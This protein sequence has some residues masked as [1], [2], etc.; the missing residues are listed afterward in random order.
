MAGNW[1]NVLKPFK[2][3]S[4]LLWIS[5]FKILCLKF[6]LNVQTSS[7]NSSNLELPALHRSAGSIQSSS[8]ALRRLRRPCTAAGR[9]APSHAHLRTQCPAEFRLDVSCHR[10]TV[11]LWSGSTRCESRT[12]SALP[13]AWPAG[14][15]SEKSPRW[16]GPPDRRCHKRFI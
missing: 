12:W 3:L 5:L 8:F 11:R 15:C 2:A 14:R 13:A 10:C 6:S 4:F 9:R 7:S 16:A 1:K